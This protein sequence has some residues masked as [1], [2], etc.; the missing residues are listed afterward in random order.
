RLK[1]PPPRPV[2]LTSAGKS[3]AAV[4]ATSRVQN[5]SELA[6]RHAHQALEN[7]TE[8]VLGEPNGACHFPPRQSPIVQQGARLQHAPLGQVLM[9]GP[10]RCPLE[11]LGEVKQA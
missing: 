9:R 8:T 10:A 5:L 1:Y 11:D 6:R 4:E 7:D 3:R 2:G